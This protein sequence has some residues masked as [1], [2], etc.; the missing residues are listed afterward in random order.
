M[1]M[2]KKRGAGD[3]DDP[4][5]PYGLK[6]SVVI[7][8]FA[9]GVLRALSRKQHTFREAIASPVCGALAAG[10]LTEPFVH[11]LRAVHFPLPP[12]DGTNVTMHAGAFLV[13]VCAMWISD[14]LFAFVA[15]RLSIK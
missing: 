5:N 2:G 15:R 9:G 13:G 14:A 4:L 1:H 7:A 3:M 8:G 10:Y 11:Y 12:D 6:I